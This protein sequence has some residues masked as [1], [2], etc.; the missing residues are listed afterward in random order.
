MR[1]FL[2]FFVC[3]LFCSSIPAQTFSTDNPVLKKIWDEGSGNSK[4]KSL[5]QVLD[6]SLG[7]RLTGSPSLKSEQDWAVSQ[8]GKWGVNAKIEN[9]GTWKGWKRGVTHIDLLEPR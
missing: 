5:A 4:L 8:Y 7:S 1:P 2:I 3:I 6:D 9:Y